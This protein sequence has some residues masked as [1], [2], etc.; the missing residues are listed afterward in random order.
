MPVP[1]SVSENTVATYQS[2]FWNSGSSWDAHK[3]G[4]TVAG[5]CTILTILISL[6][7]ILRHCRNYTNPSQQRQILRI[8]YMPPIYATISF[9]S[10]RFFRSYTYY[11]LI[12]AAYEAVTLSA[13]MLLL[14][15]I[16]ASTASDHAADKALERKGKKSL[17]IP[18]CCWRYRPSKPYF[19]YTV[20]WLVLQYVIIRPAISITGIICERLKVL[21]AAD[22]YNV[23]H[24]SVY[25]DAI[26][27]VSI[28][29]AL[30]GLI[31]F[32]GLTHE[33][34]QG[35]RPLAKFLSIK[36]I[37][38]L[39]FY[40]SFVF[41]VLEG[42]VIHGTQF[43]TA[44]NIADGLT[45]LTVCIEMVLFSALMYWSYTPNE[46]TRKEASPA[47]S[48]WRPIWDSI[49]ITDFVL[50]ITSSLS[51]FV[52][53]IRGKPSTRSNEG[54]KMDFGEA[55]GISTSRKPTIE[56][57][58][59]V[60]PKQEEEAILLSPYPFASTEHKGSVQ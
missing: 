13:F 8:L 39:T 57:M 33:E 17:P 59:P 34:L 5:G 36:L 47:T 14:I 37:V 25:L 53:Y 58:V 35:R 30:Y 54:G 41:T 7:T 6:V 3:I 4:W 29:F 38:M 45:A 48:I 10:Y 40:Q 12:Q 44:T 2:S 27:F 23:H 21:C 1:C 20:K 24:A 11:S 49:N 32:Y 56:Q 51:F 55:F 50:E 19:M 22:G 43:W 15:D 26:D 52:D 42:K 46:Y 9:F 28:S 18:F 16:V 31:M 60:Q